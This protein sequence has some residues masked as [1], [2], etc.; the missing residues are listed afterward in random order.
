MCLPKNTKNDVLKS[1]YIEKFSSTE[2]FSNSMGL[3]TFL[4]QTTMLFSSDVSNS[5]YC[6]VNDF[7]DFSCNIF[8]LK[9]VPN[10]VFI[11]HPINLI[12][13]LFCQNVTK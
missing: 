12:D 8:A 3:E 4:L 10:T 9:S 1:K 5:L 7:F 13:N 11:C 2:C 6:K